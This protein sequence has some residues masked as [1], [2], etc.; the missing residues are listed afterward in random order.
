MRKQRER[1]TN[2]QLLLEELLG[3]DDTNALVSTQH[4]LLSLAKG[5]LLLPDLPECI[6]SPLLSQNDLFGLLPHYFS[7][8]H[9]LQGINMKQNNVVCGKRRTVYPLGVREGLFFLDPPSKPK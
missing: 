9:C 3:T 2:D 5:L 1:R 7:L 4:P 6:K 8:I